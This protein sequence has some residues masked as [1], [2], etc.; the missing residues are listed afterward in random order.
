MYLCFVANGTINYET[1]AKSEKITLNYNGDNGMIEHAYI[2]S[3]IKGDAVNTKVFHAEAHQESAA[4]NHVGDMKV[5]GDNLYI[6]G[7]S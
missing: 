2:V 4:Y 7:H 3:S 1:G 6:G 5:E